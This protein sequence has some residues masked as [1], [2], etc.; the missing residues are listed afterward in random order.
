MADWSNYK[1]SLPTDLQNVLKQVTI[2]CND[3]PEKADKLHD[4]TT[5]T[6][7]VSAKELGLAPDGYEYDNE[8]ETFEYFK[9][10]NLIGM[11]TSS[12]GFWLR[13]ANSSTSGNYFC[14]DE[15]LNLY[16]ALSND[17]YNALIAFVIG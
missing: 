11:L 16:S 2:K 15:E 12:W 13:T 17:G 1:T 4:Y 8:G 7:N 6:F 3:G 14:I 10:G 9:T 5:Y